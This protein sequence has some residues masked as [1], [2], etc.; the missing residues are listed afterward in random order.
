[1]A[2]E[3]KKLA[4]RPM[5]RGG[6]SAMALTDWLLAGL[7]HAGIS[8]A[9]LGRRLG[10][11]R[12]QINKVIKGKRRLTAVE[13]QKAEQILGMRAPTEGGGPSPASTL[14]LISRPREHVNLRVVGE[15]A[16]GAW[17]EVAY[18]DFD[19]IE[20]PYA[21]DPKWPREAVWALRVRGPSI[22]KKADDGDYVAVLD[23]NAAPREFRA[24]DWVVVQRQRGDIVECT[25]KQV[26]GSPGSWLLYPASTDARFQEPVP[27]NDSTVDEVRVVGFVL[28]FIREATDF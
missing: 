2:V 18:L 12:D 16:A 3:V 15:V 24:G 26:G 13:L 10:L 5:T 23:I 4:C 17:R 6:G 28:S 8:Q 21:I 14:T 22:N 7:E 1:M 27:L 19:E 9:E 25:V 11:Q 20:I